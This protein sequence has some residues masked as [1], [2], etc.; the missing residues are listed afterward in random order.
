MKLTKLLIVLFF[1]TSM[2]AQQTNNTVENTIDNQFRKLYKKSNNY[3]DYKVVLKKSYGTL[4]NN[5]LDSIKEF[6]KKLID[7]NALISNQK[8]IISTYEKEKA[9][10]ELKLNESMN[11]E[12]TISLLGIQLKKQFYSILLFTIIIVLLLSLLFF[13]Y[14][15]KN[16]N[17]LTITSKS[18]LEDVENEF[19]AFRKKSIEREQKLRRDLQDEIIK[20]RDN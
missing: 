13:I 2:L 20:N 4:H 5:V 9:A 11:K 3:Q 6:N 8:D 17:L 15:F 19:N 7:K 16:S 10:I 14:K 12:N 1:S 18:N